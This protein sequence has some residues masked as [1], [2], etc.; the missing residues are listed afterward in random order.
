MVAPYT[1]LSSSFL[2]THLEIDYVKGSNGYVMLKSK[3][4]GGLVFGQIFAKL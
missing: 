1:L 2:Q 3:F 4:G